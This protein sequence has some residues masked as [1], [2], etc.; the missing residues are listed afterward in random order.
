M[1]LLDYTAPADR[2]ESHRRRASRHYAELGAPL[3]RPPAHLQMQMQP[4]MYAERIND[5]IW[6]GRI[7]EEPD[8][9]V[10]PHLDVRRMREH[11]L[12]EHVGG[13]R[14]LS[15]ENEPAPLPRRERDSRPRGGGAMVGPRSPAPPIVRSPGPPSNI[16]A[17]PVSAE[18]TRH[19]NPPAA[20]H[21]TSSHQ[22][23]LGRP[24]PLRST[25]LAARQARGRT[26]GGGSRDQPLVDSE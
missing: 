21:H 13:L 2:S 5:D 24:T 26:N 17:F 7:E 16:Q 6:G 8:S 15:E 11:M 19:Q 22:F 18:P 25:I 9:V 1:N 4:Q 3:S 20:Q 10:G 14:S 23:T 12:W